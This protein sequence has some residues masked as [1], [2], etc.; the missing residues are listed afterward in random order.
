MTLAHETDRRPASTTRTGAPLSRA[1][2]TLGSLVATL[3]EGAARSRAE[4]SADW[5][6]RLELQRDARRDMEAAARRARSRQIAQQSAT[7]GDV[8][9]TPRPFL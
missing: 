8:Q 7:R 6:T 3:L 9:V 2:H 4:R 1:Q 5:A